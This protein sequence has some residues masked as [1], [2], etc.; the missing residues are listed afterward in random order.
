MI[1]KG[2]VVALDLSSR[3][4]GY[5]ENRVECVSAHGSLKVA[6]F[7]DDESTSSEKVLVVEFISVCYY[8]AMSYPGVDP[9]NIEYL[10]INVNKIVEYT[11]SDLATA[12]TAHYRNIR[13]IKHYQIIFASENKR[14]DVLAESLQHTI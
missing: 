12:W 7:Y 9:S 8:A 4:P 6:I 11:Q 5:G 13:N 3:L 10:G 14:L 2:S 1:A